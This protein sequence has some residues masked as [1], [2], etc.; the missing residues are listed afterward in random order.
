MYRRLSKLEQRSIFHPVFIIRR[1]RDLRISRCIGPDRRQIRHSDIGSVSYA[2]AREQK[3]VKCRSLFIA[4]LR[5]PACA[6]RRVAS[7]RVA[8]RYSSLIPPRSKGLCPREPPRYIP[9]AILHG[10]LLRRGSRG[11]PLRAYSGLFARAHARATGAHIKLFLEFGE[12]RDH[13]SGAIKISR[14]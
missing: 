1:S 9:T 13:V 8:R 14:D 2:R 5:G 7:R 10:I 3:R 4:S 11:K 6:E 12:V